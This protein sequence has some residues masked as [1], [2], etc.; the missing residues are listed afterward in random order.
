MKKT[1][2]PTKWTVNPFQSIETKESFR[3]EWDFF[4]E[5]KNSYGK[6]TFMSKW[7]EII[8]ISHIL[9]RF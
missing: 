6:N 5:E 2:E 1:K 8:Q 9:T 4:S 7:M 3:T